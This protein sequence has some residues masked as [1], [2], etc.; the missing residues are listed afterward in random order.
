MSDFFEKI[1]HDAIKGDYLTRLLYLNIAVFVLIS[2][3]NAFAGLI[4]GKLGIGHAWALDLLSMPSDPIKLL[5][6]PWTPLTYMFTH[7]EIGR[8]HV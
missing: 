3:G 1:K 4:T 2:I 7:L 8:A 5:T 6:R